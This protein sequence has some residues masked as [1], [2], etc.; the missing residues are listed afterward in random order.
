[1]H[2]KNVYSVVFSWLQNP[3]HT[4]K[5]LQDISTRKLGTPQKTHHIFYSNMCVH[6]CTHVFMR[7]CVCM[8]MVEI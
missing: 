4:F 7:V 8:C 2:F 3:C 6:A 5:C 1:M